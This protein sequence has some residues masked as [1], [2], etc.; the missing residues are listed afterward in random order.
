MMDLFANGA[1]ELG[2]GIFWHPLRKTVFWFD[3]LGKRLLCKDVNARDGL[4]QWLFDEYVS[5]AGIINQDE[6]L[7]ASESGLYLFDLETKRRKKLVDLEADNP[8]TRSNDGRAD[9]FGGFWIGTMGK[10]AEKSA[11]SIYRYYEGELRK[12]FSGLTITN[13]ICFAPDASYACFADTT[14]QVINKVL[15]D[16]AG[17][18]ILDS[19]H[20]FIDLI[21]EDL[22]PDG[23]IIDADGNLWSAQWGAARVACYDASGK[24]LSSVA[25]PSP[26]ISCP[27]IGGESFDMLFATSAQEG[28]TAKEIEETNAGAVF[29]MELKKT[30]MAGIRGQQENFIKLGGRHEA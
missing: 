6:L 3:I 27:A 25:A 1:C 2:E 29:A 17:W 20:T 26:H 9:P 18:P 13:S 22:N 19:V 5:A 30:A 10:A 12:L 4:R 11:G 28:L 15:L 8:V 24:F 16:E 7:I 21:A 23:A 14:R